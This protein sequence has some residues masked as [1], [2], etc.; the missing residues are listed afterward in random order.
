MRPE[1]Q[2]QR[3][4]D[5]LEIRNLVVRLAHT[6]DEGS[7]DEYAGLYT[8]DAIWDGGPAFGRRRGIAD[9]LTGVRERSASGIAGPGTH[10]R[11]VITTTSV[12]VMGDTAEVRSYFLFYVDCDKAPTVRVVGAYR[13]EMRRTP[14]GWKLAHRRIRLG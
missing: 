13:D 9:I 3:I 4:A 11:H 2:F 14:S 1:E 8:E 5:E 7:L 12:R 10:T 6:A